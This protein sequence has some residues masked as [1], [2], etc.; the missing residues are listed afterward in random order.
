[1]AT[2]A[3]PAAASRDTGWLL[4]LRAATVVAAV[5]LVALAATNL[6]W[7]L[8]GGAF[9]S[10]S[11]YLGTGNALPLAIGLISTVIAFHRVHSGAD[12]RRG[13]IG[14]WIY[15]LC[16]LEIVVQC[17]ASLPAG[18]ELIW[19]PLYPLCTIGSSIG[20]AFL[21]AGAWRS[22]LAPKWMLAI[23]PPLG[24]VGS[25]LG[26]GPVPVL[27]AAFLVTLVAVVCRRATTQR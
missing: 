6:F 20:L 25:W 17:L 23:W 18:R 22:G 26:I 7:P 8:R 2:T 9:T 3:L 16:S 5:F 27:Y 19:G 12:G 15:A 21:A 24:V 1:M 14:T 10:T 13:A 11:D 4:R